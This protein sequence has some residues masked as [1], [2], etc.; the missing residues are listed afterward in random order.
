MGRYIYICVCIAWGC[1]TSRDSGKN[2]DR[3]G[4]CMRMGSLRIWGDKGYKEREYGM[5][6]LYDKGGEREGT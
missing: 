1:G 2:C 6:Y 5:L 4:V 3:Q